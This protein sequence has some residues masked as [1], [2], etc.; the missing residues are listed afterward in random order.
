VAQLLDIFSFISVLLRGLVLAFE[1]LTIGG[2]IFLS[3]IVRGRFRRQEVWLTGSSL[4]LAAV[5]SCYLAST[6]AILV[7]STDMTWTEA[8]TAQFSI[9]GALVVLGALVVARS[10]AGRSNRVFVTRG[11]ACICILCGSVMGSHSISRLEARWLVIMLTSMH[12]LG[13]DAWI[14]GMPYLIGTLRNST[15][16]VATSIISRFSW[17][18]IRAVALLLIGG[19]GMSVFYVGSAG[20]LGGTTYGIMLLGKVVMTGMLLALGASNL[21]IVR[22]IRKQA[23]AAVLPLRRFAE[24][25]A[26]IGLTI[27]L[28]AA[29]LTSMSPAIDVQRDAVTGAEII[30]RFRPTWPHMETPP[31]AALSPATPLQ[32][33]LFLSQAGSFVPGQVLH[34]DTPADKAWSE[35]NHHW[36]GLVVIAIGLVALLARRYSWARL[37]PLLFLGLAVFLLIRSDS[38]NWPLGPRGFWESFQVAE[39]AQHRVFVLLIIIFA[40]FESAVQ[41]NRLSP[42]RAGLVFPFVCAAG[43]ALLLTH[44]HSLI[45]AKEEFLVELS[46]IPLA[47]L[48]IAAGWSRWLEI[49]LPPERCRGLASIWQIC[50]VLIGAL[51]LT[52]RES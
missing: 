6:A 35:Y 43:G 52:Y 37:W 21:Q 45:N 28:A 30:Q 40:I 12:H 23:P 24:A 44:S 16:A 3:C 49:R 27:F 10:A 48:A 4:L 51:L 31:L 25:E 5:Q 20:A 29:S 38:E 39:V 11:I 26:G 32:S 22:A 36:A 9:A 18:A 2:V 13:A 34:V 7:N 1:A 46:H 50:F 14:G 15:S 33:S 19:V 42:R 17:L 47:L 8:A 41:T